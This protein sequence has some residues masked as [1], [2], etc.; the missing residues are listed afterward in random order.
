MNENLCKLFSLSLSL[1]LFFDDFEIIKQK[2]LSHFI[3]IYIVILRRN[4][5]YA[6]LLLLFFE[7]LKFKLA[8][9]KK[10]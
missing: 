2:I 6:I 8:Y 7:N 3:V 1:S 5:I 10:V 4:S 9:K